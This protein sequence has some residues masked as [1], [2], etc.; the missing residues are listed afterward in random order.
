[1]PTY[2]KSSYPWSILQMIDIQLSQK[3]L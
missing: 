3:L 1:L 2:F